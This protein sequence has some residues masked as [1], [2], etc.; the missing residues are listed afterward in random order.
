MAVK[1]TV[2]NITPEIADEMLGDYVP[3]EKIMEKYG[4]E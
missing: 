2:E 4:L 1:V 3:D